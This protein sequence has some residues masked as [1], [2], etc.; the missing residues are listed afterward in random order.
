MKEKAKIST[1][2]MVLM[3]LLTAIIVIFSCTPIGSIPIGPLVITLNVIPVAIA[4]IALGPIGGAA[5]GAIFGLFSFLQCFGIGILSPMGE[6]LVN[7]NPVLT[8]IQRVVPRTLDGLLVG[9]IFKGITKIKS[10]KGYYIL[11]GIISALF[12]V[13]LFMSAMMLVGYEKG[14]KYNMSADMYNL[15]TS[16]GLIFYICAFVSV[17]CFIIGYQIVSS[18]KLSRVQVACSVAGFCTALLNTIFFM[19]A[20]VLLFGN[21]DYMKDLIDGR[22]ILLFIVTFVGINALFEMVI[23]TIISGA[24]GSTLIKAK[25]INVSIKDS[26]EDDKKDIKKKDKKSKK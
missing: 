17:L 12:G 3:A 15:M 23:T 8:F 11:T 22:N 26:D 4:A 1:K 5:M 13:A 16:G 14:E 2:S 21:T 18:R 19:S 10:L 24:I 20:L 25:L 7:I 6:I 9:L